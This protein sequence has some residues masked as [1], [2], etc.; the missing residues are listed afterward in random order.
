MSIRV[1]CDSCSKVF[2]VSDQKAGKRIRCPDCEE[3]I[4]VPV[5]D[6][7]PALRP[8]KASSSKSRKKSKKSSSPPW[9]AIG[10][11]GGGLVVGVILAIVLLSGRKDP[12]QVAQPAPP[13]NAAPGTTTEPTTAVPPATTSAAPKAP[14]AVAWSVTVDPPPQPIEWPANWK[15]KIDVY[16][17]PETLFFR[18]HP[19]RSL[20]ISK[21]VPKCDRVRF[22]I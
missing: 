13:V 5:E 21:R 12:L 7:E 8:R 4:T 10:L 18:Q 19:V 9:L 17:G 2:G 15:G 6:D 20:L 22:G 3:I 11:G 14:V 1:T 16:G